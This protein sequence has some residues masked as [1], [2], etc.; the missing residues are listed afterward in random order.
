M[1]KF[2]KISIYYRLQDYLSGHFFYLYCTIPISCSIGV[3]SKMMRDWTVTKSC[4]LIDIWIIIFIFIPRE[5]K[6]LPVF[7][8]V[9]FFRSSIRK[10]V[11]HIHQ[12]IFAHKYTILPVLALILNWFVIMFSFF[13]KC[14]TSEVTNHFTLMTVC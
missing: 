13:D 4:L 12:H 11:W 5:K 14:I 2:K 7:L 1:S 6:A 10:N 8:N 3:L 9:N